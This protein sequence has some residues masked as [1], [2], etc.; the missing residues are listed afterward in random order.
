MVSP[1]VRYLGWDEQKGQHMYRT[2][3]GTTFHSD[4]A[5]PGVGAGGYYDP[6]TTLNDP[7]VSSQLQRAREQVYE[8]YPI[9]HRGT[10]MT[11]DRPMSEEEL[12]ALNPDVNLPPA[13]SYSDVLFGAPTL[14]DKTYADQTRRATT[15]T[16][17]KKF[18]IGRK[19]YV[20]GQRIQKE[21]EEV[22]LGAR[23]ALR[24]QITPNLRSELAVEG[25]NAN[26]PDGIAAYANSVE[27]PEKRQEL[28]AYA[29]TLKGMQEQML[30]E[31]PPSA[32]PTA[33]GYPSD[34][35]GNAVLEDTARKQAERAWRKPFDARRNTANTNY[36]NAL[37]ASDDAIGAARDEVWTGRRT[38]AALREKTLNFEIDPKRA[39]PNAFSKLMAVISVGMGAYAEGL[40][41]GKL[42][43]TA[44]QIMNDAIER[45]LQAQKL[46]Y[47]KLQGLVDTQRNVVAQ[48]I[49]MLGN[50]QRGM[51]AARTL[52][53]QTLT[54]EMKQITDEMNIDFKYKELEE[55][56]RL[57]EQKLTN[58][59]GKRAKMSKEAR[60]AIAGAGAVQALAPQLGAASEEVGEFI[61]LLT[62]INS[63]LPLDTD[64][65]TF[66]DT[67]EQLVLSIINAFSGLTMTEFEHEKFDRWTP[68]ADESM[69]LRKAKL[70]RLMRLMVARG[71]SWLP[72]EPPHVQK[73]LGEANPEL[74]WMMDPNATREE[75]DR[76]VQ[77]WVNKL[78][79]GKDGQASVMTY[80][81]L[82][83]ETV[84]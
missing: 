31:A 28:I 77:H 42:K 12:F 3:Q 62:W 59:D 74:M 49:D 41:G 18:E 25:I 63:I 27:D 75:K 29:Q 30:Q 7:P 53:Y 70:T 24:D 48:S 26:D 39:Y 17:R 35:D 15:D 8:K 60:A 9:S 34:P 6:N 54:S 10:P 16:L 1:Q 71:G 78:F 14:E 37:L 58:V 5:P 2:G 50:E 68:K 13:I 56:T 72:M 69:G 84:S 40:S 32:P 67:S 76:R 44:L 21:G 23:R 66:K 82:G 52:A 4:S 57:E 45:D 38:L 64:A 19:E 51:Q 65:K 11:G 47:Q 43:N 73:R 46:E 81:D 20:A 55:K 79:A 36:R 33:P 80:R 61:P 22:D 83:G